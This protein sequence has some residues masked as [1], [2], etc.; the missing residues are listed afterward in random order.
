MAQYYNNQTTNTIDI[1]LAVLTGFNITTSDK[2]FKTEV[3]KL[4]FDFDY[5]DG[6]TFQKVF[7]LDEDGENYD[8]SYINPLVQQISFML[9]ME[10]NIYDIDFYSLVG[11]EFLVTVEIK[12]VCN[13]T[14]YNITGCV[15]I[16]EC[17]R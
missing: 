5:G 9:G 10:P 15:L 17:I 1:G 13:R 8:W 3:H 2:R 7:Y 11:Q 6:K 12:N 4:T 14:Y 16:T